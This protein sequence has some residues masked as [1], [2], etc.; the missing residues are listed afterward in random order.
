[1]AR[2]ERL[3]AV[4]G[5]IIG[6][7]FNTAGANAHSPE[8]PVTPAWYAQVFNGYGVDPKLHNN[9]LEVIRNENTQVH[10]IVGPVSPWNGDQNGA[11][12]YQINVPWLNYMN[13]L[14]AYINAAANAKMENGISAAAPDGFA[15]QAFGRVEAPELSSTQ[16]AQEPLLALHRDEWGDAQAGFRIFE[17]WL[18]IINQ[19]EYTTGKPVYINASNT[20]DSETGR[21]PAENYPAGWLSNALAAVNEEPQIQT[22]GWFMDG[23]AHDEQWAMFS[24]TTPRGLLTEASEEFDALLLEE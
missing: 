10:V 16:Q 8:N 14:T 18:D 21:F 2:D 3:S 17:D 11:I 24:L 22:L 4:D 9:A 13:S 6:S 7:N 23:F 12:T 1:L 15:I 19:Y 5:F 20:F